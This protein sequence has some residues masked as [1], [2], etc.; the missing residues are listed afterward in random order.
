MQ[1][2]YLLGNG[3]VT[4]GYTYLQ[5]IANLGLE[6]LLPLVA[7]RADAPAE[8]SPL[9]PLKHFIFQ[10]HYVIFPVVSSVGE[11]VIFYGEL[12]TAPL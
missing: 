3:S 7:S 9:K 12:I 10:I 2:C 5:G 8:T 4:A 1:P 11:H 6:L